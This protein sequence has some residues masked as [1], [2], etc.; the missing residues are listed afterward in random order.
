MFSVKRRMAQGG[1]GLQNIDVIAR[2]ERKRLTKQSKILI[3]N[4]QF[5]NFRSPRR[6]IVLLAMT[7]FQT[8]YTNMRSLECFHLLFLRSFLCRRLLSVHVTIGSSRHFDSFFFE[9]IYCLLKEFD[10]ALPLT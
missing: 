6:T 10:K 8:G 1:S 2:K 7:S 5:Q 4:C 3:K 9:M